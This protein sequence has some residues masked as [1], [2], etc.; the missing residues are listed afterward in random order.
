MRIDT[1]ARRIELLGACQGLEGEAEQAAEAIRGFQP[2]VVALGLDPHVV[3][4]VHEFQEGSPFSVED[5]AYRRGLEAFGEVRLPP[6]E[7]AAAV[8]AAADVGAELRGV[9][10]PEPEYMQRYTDIVGVLDLTRRAF[11]V[12]WLKTKPPKTESPRAF[13]KAF[14]ERINQGPYRELERVR[15]REIAH[16]LRDL[17]EAGSVACVL[18][19]QRLEGVEAALEAPKTASEPA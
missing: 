8:E 11:R 1:A 9:D 15:E 4:H 14:D 12:R 10:M 7:Y 18:E 5:E 19:I 16:R 3:E 13:C 2:D 17:A 6:P